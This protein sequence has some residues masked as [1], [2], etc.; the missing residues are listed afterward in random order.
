MQPTLMELFFLFFYIGLFTIG[1]GLVAITLMQQQL[2]DKGLIS[3]ETFVN[4][5][6]IS[7]STPGP[8]GVN[9][10][11]YIGNYYYGVIGG[12]VT[13]IAEILPSIIIILLIAKLFTK[14][15]EKPIVKSAFKTLK[16]VSSGLILVA[17]LQVFTVAL[18]NSDFNINSILQINSIQKFLSFFKIKQCLFFAVSLGLLFIKKINPIYLIII[19]AIFGILFL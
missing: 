18:L 19:G 13:T 6:A 14:F 7:E 9:M 1:G 17:A 2:V 15:Q 16:P 8:V 4:M 12:I 3:S 10:A 11:T 5:I